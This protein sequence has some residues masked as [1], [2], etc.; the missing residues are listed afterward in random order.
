MVAGEGSLR[1]RAGQ[2]GSDR[3][4]GEGAAVEGPGGF[5]PQ[6]A[7]GEGRPHGVWEGGGKI[8]LD[9][10]F[11]ARRLPCYARPVRRR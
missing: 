5:W 1:A 6:P 4:L 3:P 8:S 7:A 10:W 2:L 9:G 11:G